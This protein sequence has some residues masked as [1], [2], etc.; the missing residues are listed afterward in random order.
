MMLK[1]AGKQG[2]GYECYSSGINK[3]K[4]AAAPSFIHGAGT[5]HS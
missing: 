3:L 4:D 2:Y 1:K 5:P